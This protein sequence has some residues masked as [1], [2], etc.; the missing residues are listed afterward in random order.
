M[1]KLNLEYISTKDD[2]YYFKMIEPEK[3]LKKQEYEEGTESYYPFFKGKDSDD[4]LLKVKSKYLGDSKIDKENKDAVY[5]TAV[6]LKDFRMQ[7]KDKKLKYGK[8]VNHFKII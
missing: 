6:S 4:Y 2:A 5:D 7:S 3:F 8:F 1:S